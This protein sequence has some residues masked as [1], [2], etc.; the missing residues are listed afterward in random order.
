ML[1]MS[2]DPTVVNRPLKIKDIRV[3]GQV[4]VEVQDE[5]GVVA[6]VLDEL[7]SAA[8]SFKEEQ[9]GWWNNTAEF[10]RIS[11]TENGREKVFAP[12]PASLLLGDFGGNGEFLDRM[13]MIGILLGVHLNTLFHSMSVSLTVPL[14]GVV[15]QR[16]IEPDS[17]IDES[18]ALESAICA[19]AM[20]ASELGEAPE[21]AYEQGLGYWPTVEAVRNGTSIRKQWDRQCVATV[22]L[23]L[24]KTSSP[25]F[26][27]MLKGFQST[28][29]IGQSSHYFSPALANGMLLGE[30]HITMA[31]LISRLE[32]PE[33]A[34][35]KDWNRKFL[36]ALEKLGAE[37][38]LHLKE[39]VRQV[40]GVPQLRRSPSSGPIRIY[41]VKPPV[42]Y[43]SQISTC[44]HSLYLALPSNVDASKWLEKEL[45]ELVSSSSSETFNTA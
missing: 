2:R 19:R 12:A 38:P 42:A 23:M 8:F 11:E 33:G 31:L 26:D 34:E 15:L 27:A 37:D 28:V 43:T 14:D 6:A 41:W 9:Y 18:D 25:A 40:T 17:I 1:E 20:K 24:N 4:M 16:L 29:P 7:T 45:R 10:V 5:G 32:L 39:F 36:K 30:R 21:A 35:F 13:K 22:H 3:E 44:Y